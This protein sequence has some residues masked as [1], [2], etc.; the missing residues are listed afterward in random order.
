MVWHSS[1]QPFLSFQGAVN[2]TTGIFPCAFVKIIKDL[3]QQE[4]TV[5]KVRCYYHDETV[6][7]I[8]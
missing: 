6:S 2:D 5:N 1:F 7:T 8:R 3:P 4:D